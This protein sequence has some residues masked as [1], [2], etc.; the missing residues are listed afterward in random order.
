MEWR[1]VRSNVLYSPGVQRYVE[2]Y[3]HAFR[4]MI[5]DSRWLDQLCWCNGIA[6][7]A[8]LLE[9]LYWPGITN[10]IVNRT[11]PTKTGELT[12]SNYSD[13]IKQYKD[14]ALDVLRRIPK[15]IVAKAHMELRIEAARW[16]NNHELYLLLRSSL[17]S[18]REKLEG[19][20]GTALW[21]RHIAEV[22]RHGY[23]ELYDDRLVHED[24]AFGTWLPGARKWA[25]GS[26]Y[27]LEHMREMVRR[28]LPHWGITT[29]IR[30][31]FY[32]EG[33]TEQGALEVGLEGLLGFGVEIVNVRA[34]GWTTWLKQ[35]LENDLQAKR[36][37]LLMLD[38]DQDDPLRALRKRAEEGLIVGMVFINDPDI[39][40][41]CFSPQQLC[42]AAAI[43]E[44]SIGMTNFDPLD[45]T[46]FADVK[47]GKEFEQRYCKER[48]TQHL[49]GR[50]W[51]AALMQV[52][53]ASRSDSSDELNPLVHAVMCAFRGVMAD[54]D[55]HA[56]RMRVDPRNL[57]SIDTGHGPF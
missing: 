25:Y 53:F 28:I 36:F 39:E 29:G 31:R 14:R 46:K 18:K 27:P 17:W 33:D 44:V 34:Q 4:R 8:I 47:A 16:D 40:R 38:A 56:I 52:A 45:H 21:L 43:Y 1:L 26:E 30:V 19:Q 22:I 5:R 6:D 24:E 49:K 51:G 37:S 15:A 3:V 35:E 20:L 54:Y 41:G 9:P 42:E 23:D 10:R 48:M 2:S 13:H 57:K 55:A 11:M 50:E 7:L 32:V 12:F